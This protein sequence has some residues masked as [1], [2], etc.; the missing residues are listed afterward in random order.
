MSQNP[1][2]QLW[3]NIKELTEADLPAP[4]E[5]GLKIKLQ[6]EYDSHK[7][8]LET[9][10][11]DSFGEKLKELEGRH[12]K[13]IADIIDEGYDDNDPTGHCLDRQYDY[14]SYPLHSDLV[15]VKKD[16][17]KFA[18]EILG[19][20]SEDEE[21]YEQA[22]SNIIKALLFLVDQN[23][24][25]MDKQPFI[26]TCIDKEGKSLET[27]SPHQV[28]ETIYQLYNEGF[29]EKVRNGLISREDADI[30]LMVRLEMI[31]RDWGV[32]A[33][34]KDPEARHYIERLKRDELRQKIR[35]IRED[36][37]E[38]FN[39]AWKTVR[40]AQEKYAE[41]DER[42][43]GEQININMNTILT[44]LSTYEL[45]EHALIL[46]KKEDQNTLRVVGSDESEGLNREERLRTLNEEQSIATLRFIHMLVE[47][48][49][50]FQAAKKETANLRINVLRSL[51]PDE[52]HTN[53]RLEKLAE[54]IIKIKKKVK[55][56]QEIDQKLKA[57]GIH[58]E[59][60]ENDFDTLNDEDI[61][62]EI[63]PDNGEWSLKD[64]ES[65][66]P[67]FLDQSKTQEL[68]Q[69]RNALSGELE[70]EDNDLE[71]LMKE[72]K[73]FNLR[74]DITN[75]D[76]HGDYV[77]QK[78]DR[79]KTEIQKLVS[80]DPSLEEE[81]GDQFIC[82]QADAFR[83]KKRKS[84]VDKVQND[85]ERKIGKDIRDLNGFRIRL[86]NITLADIDGPKS[87]LYTRWVEKLL[88]KIGK[89]YTYE[90]KGRTKKLKQVFR[91][92]DLTLGTFFVEMEKLTKGT[93]NKKS[94]KIRVGKI[95]MITL[96]G[97]EQEGQAVPK[98]EDARFHSKKSKAERER[99]DTRKQINMLRANLI[100]SNYERPFEVMKYVEENLDKED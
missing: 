36:V 93:N 79:Y 86:E 60:L 68:I 21:D 24:R 47:L 5:Q 84:V 18:E 37:H 16:M 27:V 88:I 26:Q 77:P 67:E 20:S 69:E 89:D 15:K 98:D 10:I 65:S 62:G 76:Q 34:I 99:Y 6:P 39:D 19:S 61:L 33:K 46:W 11:R 72:F 57:K 52:L 74:I 82:I 95:Y 17:Q 70:N 58:P 12:K 23:V 41:Q 94:G 22:H 14:M 9:K 92:E 53:K 54:R 59:D 32:P 56:L 31:D 7:T 91:K 3:A 85:P 64:E 90:Y 2:I 44:S 25:R 83:N 4:G 40:K 29:G 48:S 51:S 43:K 35:Q 71:R 63:A 49:P 66:P 45:L 97:V 73:S 100:K 75:L 87:E 13:F 28:R 30:E 80:I 78:T 55:R 38:H 8:E 50:A 81:I 1:Q 96:D 42:L